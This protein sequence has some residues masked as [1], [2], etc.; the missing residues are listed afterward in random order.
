MGSLNEKIS[1]H[2]YKC[3]HLLGTLYTFVT[4]NPQDLG[5]EGFRKG[6]VILLGSRPPPSDHWRWQPWVNPGPWQSWHYPR[7]PEGGS[8]ATGPRNLNFHNVFKWV[9]LN[10][11]KSENRF[12]K[13]YTHHES[14]EGQ[15]DASF[16]EK[17]ETW[18]E[19]LLFPKFHGTVSYIYAC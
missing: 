17:H 12:P 18:T 14:Q 5:T 1:T 4:F 9:L 13:H 10:T 3:S 15:Q 11:V 19:T 6:W 7:L 8:L 2:R 16:L